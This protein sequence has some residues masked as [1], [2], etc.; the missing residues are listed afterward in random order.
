MDISVCVAVGD[1]ECEAVATDCGPDAAGDL[2]R[3][4][5]THTMVMVSAEA[6]AAAVAAPTGESSAEG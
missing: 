4:V 3:Q 2:M 5:T 6:I 1:F